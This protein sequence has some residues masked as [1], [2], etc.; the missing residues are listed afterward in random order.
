MTR[1]NA[2]K[3]PNRPDF[4]V[5]ARG[6]AFGAERRTATRN[7]LLILGA[8]VSV[9]LIGPAE[10]MGSSFMSIGQV[11]AA[12]VAGIAE[13]IRQRSPGFRTRADIGKGKFVRPRPVARAKPRIRRP[14]A[15][16][17]APARP[18][19]PLLVPPAA[20]PLAF[21]GNDLAPP[22][23]VIGQF[24]GYDFSGPC[25]CGFAFLQ[26]GQGPGLIFFAP[27][28]GGGGGGGVLLPPPPG[29][30]VPNPPA[31]PEASTWAMMI[32]GF[33]VIG[34]LWRRRRQIIRAM[35]GALL[36][37][38]GYVPVRLLSDRRV[39]SF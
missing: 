21:F 20:T 33:G 9:A 25:D 6:R 2:D 23:P 11:A 30:V 15:S 18:A 39:R 3:R 16:V 8:A 31:I 19:A 26:P 1:L 12:G 13:T 17:A 37:L 7:K 29:G 32:F 14:I 24:P 28:G 36:P 35:A 38:L 4:L 27:G 22:G 34:T 10:H 5:D